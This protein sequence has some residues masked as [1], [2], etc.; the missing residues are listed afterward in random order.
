VTTS[1]SPASASRY[2]PPPGLLVSFPFY[3]HFHPLCLPS[4]LLVTDVSGDPSAPPASASRYLPPPGRWS[5]L[6]L[7]FPLFPSYVFRPCLLVTGVLDDPR[8][9]AALRPRRRAC[10]RRTPAAC[11]RATAQ[12]ASAS[13]HAREAARHRSAAVPG[14]ARQ[15]WEPNVVIV[16]GRLAAGRN[17]CKRLSAQPC[18]PLT[19]GHACLGLSAPLSSPRAGRAPVVRLRLRPLH[20]LDAQQRRREAAHDGG[21][22]VRRAGVAVVHRLV[23]CLRQHHAVQRVLRRQAAPPQRA[24]P[25]RM[26]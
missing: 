2:L 23:H 7:F 15:S 17:Q 6:P 5:V 10:A 21:Q 1:A 13:K 14:E 12:E 3:P 19:G 16:A 20:A 8:G 11:T 25:S 22:H 9:A 24:P 26:H 18:V 4:C